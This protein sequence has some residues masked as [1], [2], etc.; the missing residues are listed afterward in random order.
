MNLYEAVYARKSVRC[1]A[2]EAVSGKTIESI[3]KFY[4]EMEGLFGGIETE[5]GDPGEP[6]GKTVF[7]GL[8][9]R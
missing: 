6:E 9:Q 4:Q 8:C 2:K 1:F 5:T 7:Y 3:R